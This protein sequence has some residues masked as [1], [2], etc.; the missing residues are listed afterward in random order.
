MDQDFNKFSVRFCRLLLCLGW[1]VLV[2]LLCCPLGYII[3]SFLHHCYYWLVFSGLV[4]VVV[5][6]TVRLVYVYVWMYGVVSFA[7]TFPL[8]FVL[9]LGARYVWIIVVPVKLRISSF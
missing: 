8:A 2:S 7:S 1:D 4:S 9:L 3:V 5:G 6:V